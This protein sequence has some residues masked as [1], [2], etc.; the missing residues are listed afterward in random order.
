MTNKTI[1]R[2][3]LIGTIVTVISIFSPLLLWFLEALNLMALNEVLGYILLPAMTIFM[4]ILG[5]GLWTKAPSS[6]PE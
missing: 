3:G 1:I 6:R 2:I 4:I 5:I